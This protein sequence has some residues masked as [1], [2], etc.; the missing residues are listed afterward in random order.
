MIKNLVD[1]FY[2][3]PRILCILAILFVSMFALDAFSPGLRWW[4]QIRDFL[5]HLIPSYILLLFLWVAWI[6]EKL[7]GI[8]FIVIGTITTPPVFLL[9]YHRTGSI[10]VGIGIVFLITMPFIMVGA[11]FLISNYLKKNSAEG[12]KKTVK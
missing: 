5:I 8:L 10:W 7:G 3:I 2:W 9:N 1:W 4:E 6:K 11:M 12:I